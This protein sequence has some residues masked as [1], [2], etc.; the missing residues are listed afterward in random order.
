MSSYLQRIT[1]SA[2][3]KQVTISS[4]VRSKFNKVH[5]FDGGIF[6]NLYTLSIYQ[7]HHWI[8]FQNT[9]NNI[10]LHNANRHLS[11]SNINLFNHNTLIYYHQTRFMSRDIDP[12]DDSD[13][14]QHARNKYDKRMR[15]REIE[16]ERER[17]TDFRSKPKIKNKHTKLRRAI[18]RHITKEV[19][20]YNYV[21]PQLTKREKR[22]RLMRDI[23]NQ[24]ALDPVKLS[25]QEVE[26]R[27]SELKRGTHLYNISRQH[28]LKDV[29]T[30][31]A[32]RILKE[33]FEKLKRPTGGTNRVQILYMKIWEAMMKGNARVR[34]AKYHLQG[35]IINVFYE[36]T[37]EAKSISFL[38]I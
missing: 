6:K 26:R 1:H 12:S 17:V 20:R 31:A 38:D 28:E 9:N 25:D 19:N 22:M 16:Q 2:R 7:N 29:G 30:K 10:A 21:P 13:P 3:Y 4:I 33:Q 18:S 14:K 32:T 27:E 34:L 5:A 24:E 36:I 35:D 8:R 23:K 37:E 15:S 11:F